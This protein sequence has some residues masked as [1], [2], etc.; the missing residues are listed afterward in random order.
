YRRSHVLDPGIRFRFRASLL[1]F[2]FSSQLLLQSLQAFLN[3]INL[4]FGRLDALGRFL[5]KRM[6]DPNLIAELHSI[7]HPKRIAMKGESNLEY[8][9]P[10]A[11]HG[12]RD[13]GLAALRGDRQSS[14]TD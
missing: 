5:L 8:P 1:T 2:P 13:V 9:G 6:D 3:E 12:L 11:V 7:D 10:Q 4:M 14:E